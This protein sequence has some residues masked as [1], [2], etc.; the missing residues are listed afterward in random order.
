MPDSIN[1]CFPLLANSL[2]VPSE[3]ASVEILK[4]RS[5]HVC[6]AAV[7]EHDESVGK[8]A[9]RENDFPHVAL[10]KISAHHAIANLLGHQVGGGRPAGLKVPRIAA[11]AGA[12]REE[13]E[14]EEARVPEAVTEIHVEQLD[15]TLLHAARQAFSGQKS[16]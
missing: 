8:G 11:R 1:T 12:E 6:A 14:L 7:V 5:G 16:S 2:D 9:H 3:R 10:S 13:H 4:L 15:E